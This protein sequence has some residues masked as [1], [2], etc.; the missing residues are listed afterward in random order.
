MIYVCSLEEM[1]QHAHALCPSHLV[2]VVAP[3]E[4]PP[5]PPGIHADRHLRLGIHD[6]S[7]PIGGQILP[8]TDHVAT[9]IEFIR[10][11]RAEAPLLMHCVAGI[12]RSMAAALIA[13]NLKTGECEVEAACR[14]RQI[15]PHARPNRRM[16]ALADR[17]LGRDG[18][19]VAACEAMGPAEPR[20]LGPL[21]GFPLP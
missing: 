3:E 21:V 5:T 15:A 19:L 8:D 13:L 4:Q 11:W 10:G 9:L 20:S 12:S 16:I 6:I 17:L 2:S 1:P 18:R 7:E 14:M